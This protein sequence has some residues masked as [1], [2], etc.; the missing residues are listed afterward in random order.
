V[1]ERRRPMDA[2]SG[3]RR[4]RKHHKLAARRESIKDTQAVDCYSRPCQLFCDHTDGALLVKPTGILVGARWVLDKPAEK[5]AW[6][7]YDG[8]TWFDSPRLGL[9]HESPQA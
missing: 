8:S 3:V 1:L 4:R 5:L 7:R 2:L 6:C 9:R